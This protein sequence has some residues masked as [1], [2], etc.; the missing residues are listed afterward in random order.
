MNPMKSL[1]KAEVTIDGDI[2]TA[3]PGAECDPGGVERTTKE[4]GNFSEEDKFGYVEFEI[5]FTPD[6]SIREIE[7]KDD[8]TVRFVSDTGQVYVGNHWYFANRGPIKD[9]KDSKLKIRFEGPEMKEIA[10]NG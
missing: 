1:G 9:G 10:A 7:A 5:D 4:T 3:Y 2:Y 8:A 6:I